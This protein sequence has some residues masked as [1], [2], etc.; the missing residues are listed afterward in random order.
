MKYELKF[1]QAWK[2]LLHDNWDTIAGDKVNK[3]K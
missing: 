1:Y 3:V 2:I